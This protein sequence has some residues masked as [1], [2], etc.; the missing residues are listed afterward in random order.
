MDKKG[1]VIKSF[2]EE[3]KYYFILYTPNF[4]DY[5]K[6]FS[7]YGESDKSYE[8]ALNK[9]VYD[10]SRNISKRKLLVRRLKSYLEGISIVLEEGT[11]LQE[12]EIL[13]RVANNINFL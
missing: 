5:I 9:M 3:D 1:I 6:Q 11:N 4:D 7:G 13:S 10:L 8:D 2:R 12:S